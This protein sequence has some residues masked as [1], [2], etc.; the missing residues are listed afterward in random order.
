VNIADLALYPAPDM[1]EGVVAVWVR[2]G[3]S[4]RAHSIIEGLGLPVAPA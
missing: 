1:S 3:Q 2:G 4:A